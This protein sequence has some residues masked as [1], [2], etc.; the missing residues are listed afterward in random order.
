MENN[1]QIQQETKELQNVQPIQEPNAPQNNLGTP[2][3][4]LGIASFIVAMVA[5]LFTILSI[6]LPFVALSSKNQ[7][8]TTVMGI[9][10]IISPLLALILSVIG[11]VLSS[12]SKKQG[13]RGG[14]RGAGFGISL[15]FL[16]LD[17]I[18][19]L[20]ILS[21]VGCMGYLY[22][23]TKKTQESMYN[24]ALDRTEDMYDNTLDH[25]FGE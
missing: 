15:S 4:G 1:N 21:C 24:D 20:I 10:V 6:V 5:V 12:I 7:T 8:A 3:K 18:A 2:G 9:I 25:V 14:L 22:Q 19:F 17:G 11:L 23:D 13:F 16:I